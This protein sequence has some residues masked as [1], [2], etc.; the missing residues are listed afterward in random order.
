MTGTDSLSLLLHGSVIASGSAAAFFA[1]R[2][3]FRPAPRSAGLAA[4]FAIASACLVLADWLV[5]LVRD[6]QRGPGSSVWV[7][8]FDSFVILG[9]A[10]IPCFLLLY[11]P[12]PGLRAL[13]YL[14]G[15]GSALAWIGWHTLTHAIPLG[16]GAD[17]A[18]LTVAACLVGFAFLNFMLIVPSARAQSLSRPARF[19]TQQIRL[20]WTTTAAAYAIAVAFAVTGLWRAMG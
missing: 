18:G 13:L 6:A 15:C 11:L 10:W 12:S 14:G 9:I 17:T 5:L 19:S 2:Q 3:S 4:R 8:F 1:A 7:T 16:A 20:G